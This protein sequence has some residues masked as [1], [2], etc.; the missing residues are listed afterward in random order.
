VKNLSKINYNNPNIKI[1]HFF[2]QEKKNKSKHVFV[3]N[4][5]HVEASSEKN[6]MKE[7]KFI[8]KDIKIN[9][10]LSD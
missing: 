5:F 1:L 10:L 6:E 4:F 2:V 3:L 9:F 8:N 7:K